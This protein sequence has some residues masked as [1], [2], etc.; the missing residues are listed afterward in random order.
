MLPVCL[1]IKKLLK[2]FIQSFTLYFLGYYLVLSPP[3][4]SSHSSAQNTVHFISALPTLKSLFFLH[5]N[6]TKHENTKIERERDKRKR[7]K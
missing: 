6:K 5:A 4:S 7:A 3:P 1:Y 2:I